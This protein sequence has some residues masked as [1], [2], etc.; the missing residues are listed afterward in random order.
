MG[1]WIRH[2]KVIAPPPLSLEVG[3]MTAVASAFGLGT[4]L[5]KLK[6]ALDEQAWLKQ[7]WQAET[8]GATRQDLE[9]LV[10]QDKQHGHLIHFAVHGLSDPEG[11]DQA[12]LLADK[13]RLLPSALAGRYRC[14]EV[15]PFSFV[16]LNACQVGTAANCLGQAAG[17]PGDLIRGGALGF[18]APL[19]DV[20]DALALQIAQNFYTATLGDGQPVGD[21]LYAERARYQPAG[22]TTPL[23]YIYY[24]HPRLR[25]KPA[26]S[27]G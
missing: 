16:F 10:L 18:I 13:T 9:P 12:L 7:H 3:R 19:W 17:F 23:A 20:D 25:L 22:S 15:P 2:D 21:V 27:D 5:A 8:L 4:D 1:R 24:G 6:H 14:G 11:N 26:A